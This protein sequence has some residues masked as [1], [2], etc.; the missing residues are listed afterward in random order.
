MMGMLLSGYRISMIIFAVTLV[1]SIPLG[2][3]VALGRLSKFKP[4]SLLMQ[5]F[6][7]VLRGTLLVIWQGGEDRMRFPSDSVEK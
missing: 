7:S 2:M 6:I 1:G 3:L 4:L 5:L